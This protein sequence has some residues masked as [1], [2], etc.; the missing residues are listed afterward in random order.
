GER[1]AKEF[2]AATR[3][4]HAEPALVTMAHLYAARAFDLA[5]KR[6]DAL[7]QYREVL[8]RPDIYAAHEEAKKGL[9]QPFKNE[10]ASTGL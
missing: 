10:I 5:G 8:T 2:L 7:S 3:V 4:E 9:R 1:A 6:E